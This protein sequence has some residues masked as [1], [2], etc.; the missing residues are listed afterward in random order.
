MNTA[1]VAESVNATT[2][3]PVAKVTAIAQGSTA[4]AAEKPKAPAQ[5]GR[6]FSLRPFFLKVLPPLFGVFFL[7][8]VWEIVAAR[9]SGIPSPLTT[10]KA[11]L[12]LFADPFYDNGPNDQGIGWNVLASLKR[13]GLG[14]GMAALVGIPLGFI[15]GRFSFFSG[16]F[17]PIISLL[18]PVSPLAWLP[19]GLLVFK[20]ADP[21]AIWA[22]FI[23]SIWPMIINTAVGVQRVPQDYMNVARVLNL[24]EWKIVTKI[25]FPSVLP[26]MLTGVRLAI[27]TAWLVIVAAEML[28]GGV[29]IGFWVW[30]E[31]NNLNVPHIIIAIV[32]IGVVGLILEQMLVGIAR[33]FTYEEVK[34]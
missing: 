31:W 9:N 8:V 6:P 26:Y 32:V 12:E 33:A 16:M 3:A 10:W 24:S 27:G 15:I 1:V 13:V 21:A 25:L 5:P 18:K 34:S 17:N 7:I 20:A 30:D 19:I 4:A 2:E 22:I 23:C 14:F 11:A 29:G 28:T